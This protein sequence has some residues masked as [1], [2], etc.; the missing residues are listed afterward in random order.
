MINLVYRIV[1]KLDDEELEVSNIEIKNGRV[2]IDGIFTIE[3]GGDT[4]ALQVNTSTGSKLQGFR[5]E[6]LHINDVLRA[7][8]REIEKSRNFSIGFIVEKDGKYYMLIPGKKYPIPFQL[9]DLEDNKVDNRGVDS[10]YLYKKGYN[11]VNNY[12]DLV[13]EGKEND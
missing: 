4:Y 12:L 8:V 7:L 10:T 9:L 3:D 5:E 11:V 2:V 6:Y 1:S 13:L